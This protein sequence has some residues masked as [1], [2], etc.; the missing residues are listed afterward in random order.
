MFI[1]SQYFSLFYQKKMS[2][3]TPEEQAPTSA[4]ALVLRSEVAPQRCLLS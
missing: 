1:L 3:R 4:V 2:G